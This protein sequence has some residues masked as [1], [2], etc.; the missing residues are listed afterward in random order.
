MTLPAGFKR[1]VTLV[2][3]E[4]GD[5]MSVELATDTAEKA[6]RRVKFAM[7]ARFGDPERY[8]IVGTRELPPN[9]TEQ[10]VEDVVRLIAE[11]Y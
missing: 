1:F 10:D 7:L 3:P 4:E 9:A 8:E 5:P 2:L 11:A 6:E